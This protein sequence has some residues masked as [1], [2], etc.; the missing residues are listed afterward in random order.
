MPC[1][2]DTPWYTGILLIYLA[3]Q[4]FKTT[5]AGSNYGSSEKVAESTGGKVD[6]MERRLMI[7]R[8][9]WSRSQQEN[10]QTYKTFRSVDLHQLYEKTDEMYLQRGGDWQVDQRKTEEA[11]Y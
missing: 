8:S 11:L 6:G 10:I 1:T 5:E 9:Y 7:G 3:D 4:A 2:T